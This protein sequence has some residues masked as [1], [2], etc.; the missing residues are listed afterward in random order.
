MKTKRLTMAQI[1]RL[2][3]DAGR[4]YEILEALTK[5]HLGKVDETMDTVAELQGSA[6]ALLERIDSQAE[7]DAYQRRRPNIR[8]EYDGDMPDREYDDANA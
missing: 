1:R 3:A 6:I 7:Y 5:V 2:G 4:I 8:T